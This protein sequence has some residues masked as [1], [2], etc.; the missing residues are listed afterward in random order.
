[1]A[2]LVPSSS[3]LI[4]RAE[5]R[6]ILVREGVLDPHDAV[7]G[8]WADAARDGVIRKWGADETQR[9]LATAFAARST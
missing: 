9:L 5:A 1:M 8:L 4:A 7:D 2:T 3:A 6:G